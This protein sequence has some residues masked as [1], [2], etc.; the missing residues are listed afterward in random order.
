MGISREMRTREREFTGLAEPVTRKCSFSRKAQHQE[1]GKEF[2]GALSLSLIFS[3]ISI[4]E[5]QVYLQNVYDCN[6]RMLFFQVTATGW[7][8]DV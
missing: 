6:L 7:I 8:I 3:N 2:H 4:T 5:M 1:L